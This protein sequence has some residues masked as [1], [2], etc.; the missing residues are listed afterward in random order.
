[1]DGSSEDEGSAP[2][3]ADPSRVTTPAELAAALRELRLRRGEPSLRELERRARSPAAVA[4]GT[5]ALSRT[6]L[7]GILSGHRFPSHDVLIAFLA[8]VGVV[9]ETEQREWTAARERLARLRD[10][11]APAA[12]EPQHPRQRSPQRWW[13]AGAVVLAV[14]SVVIAIAVARPVPT[15]P[16]VLTATMGCVPADCAAEGPTVI[17]QGRLTG[18]VPPD[19]RV[20]VMILVDRTQRWYLGPTIVGDEVEWTRQI[21]VGNPVPQPSDRFFT[22][23]LNVVPADSI[24]RLTA[25]MIARAGEGLAE[26]ALPADRVE[27]ACVP[28]VRPAGT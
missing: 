13:T 27:L 22:V 16:E 5:V 3:D 6:T 20:V 8:A 15:R 23:C 9:E 4:A 18:S 14:A 21:G 26:E 11:P 12:A 2:L 25:E 24:E 28:A 7:S 17:L 10:G 1:V 19:R